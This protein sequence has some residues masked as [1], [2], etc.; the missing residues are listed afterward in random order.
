MLRFRIV[1]LICVSVILSNSLTAQEKKDSLPSEVKIDSC[2]NL[3]N[4][5]KK[6]YILINRPSIGNH[7]S[8][9]IG[10]FD[11]KDGETKY[12]TSWEIK[13]K[14]KKS[15]SNVF[16]AVA[17]QYD[18]G[19][20]SDTNEMLK[21][22]NN[23]YKLFQSVSWLSEKIQI[24]TTIKIE[25]HF[26]KG[27]SFSYKAQ[28]SFLSD[29]SLFN[30]GDER[31]MEELLPQLTQSVFLEITEGD[32][33]YSRWIVLP[34]KEMILWHY[35]GDTVLDFNLE[36]IKYGNYYGHKSVFLRVTPEGKIITPN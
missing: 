16:I 7:G 33:K 31:M 30:D 26:T 5:F 35:K 22:I 13:L 15:N 19:K 18:S 14:R 8:I 28:T 25:L 12:A 1:I 10:M 2:L 24:D 4:Q 20:V 32:G 17:L 29:L 3:L 27:L 23:Y 9:D 21:K 6:D 36:T 11:D 34:N